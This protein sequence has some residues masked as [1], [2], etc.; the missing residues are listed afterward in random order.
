MANVAINNGAWALVADGRRALFLFNHGDADLLDLRVMSA[1][2]DVNPPA[3]EWGSERPGRAFSSVGRRRSAVEETDWHVHEEALFVKAVAD[4]LNVAAEKN[5][6]KEFVVVAPPKVIGELRKELSAK[7]HAKLV[8][9]LHKDMT[10]HP[11]PEIEKA[12][13]RR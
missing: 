11:L 6:M 1:R 8:G 13:A 4:E 9:E 10:R 12:L 2:V 5:E 7:A 3:G